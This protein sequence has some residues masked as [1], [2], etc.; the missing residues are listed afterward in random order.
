MF[1]KGNNI[2][3]PAP[4]RRQQTARARSTHIRGSHRPCPPPARK[5]QLPPA[6]GAREGTAAAVTVAGGPPAT[7]IT[8]G[9]G[10]VC[11]AAIHRRPAPE[12]PHGADPRHW[13]YRRGPAA[14]L[15]PPGPPGRLSGPPA[16]PGGGGAAAEPGRSP[17]PLLR[18]RRATRGGGGGAA[19]FISA[20]QS[21]G[22]GRSGRPSPPRRNAPTYPPSL[23][24]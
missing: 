8:R 23:Q 11:L 22:G 9:A 20:W 5:A 4:T 13:S 14:P 24:R 3:C 15:P 17:P 6:G 19:A 1:E 2:F 10:R 12:P 7:L 18:L 16:P 21:T